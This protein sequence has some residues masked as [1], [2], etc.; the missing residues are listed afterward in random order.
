MNEEILQQK[1]YYNQYNAKRYEQLL[2]NP[3]SLFGTSL[4]MDYF[5]PNRIVDAKI[6]ESISNSDTHILDL[7][8]GEGGWSC[9]LASLGAQ[10]TALDNSDVNVKITEL[11]ASRNKVKNV[12]AIVGSCTHTGLLPESFDIIIVMALIHHLT[13]DLE[14]LTYKEIYRLLK[15]GGVAIIME[16]IMNSKALDYIRTLIPVNQELDKRPSK[17]SK[18]YEEFLKND[19]HPERPNNTKHYKNIFNSFDFKKVEM[20]EVGILSRL[21]RVVKSNKLKRFIHDFDNKI[22]PIVPFS[23]LFSRNIVISLHK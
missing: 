21:D 3:K 11:K 6:K 22:K 7:G 4:P 23:S 16:S 19:P 17:L 14:K 2:D 15:P 1:H 8:C 12:K 13:V 18:S 9:Y 5:L 20:E 10:V